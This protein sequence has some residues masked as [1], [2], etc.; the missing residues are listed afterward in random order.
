MDLERS[1]SG[2]ALRLI[3]QRKGTGEGEYRS[4]C[5][6][7]GHELLE[8]VADERFR[9]GRFQRHFSFF[10]DFGKA[11]RN[12]AEDGDRSP[13]QALVAESLRLIGRLAA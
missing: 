4:F 2:M 13:T 6:P 3:K 5:E 7:Q 10:E 9:A 8:L 1:I 11:A 12:G